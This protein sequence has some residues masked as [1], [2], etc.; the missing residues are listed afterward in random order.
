MKK[1]F[2]GA[3]M[4]LCMILGMTVFAFADTVTPLN[5]TGINLAEAIGSGLTDMVGEIMAVIAV[6]LPMALML[7]GAV[8]AIR[9]GISLMRS[10]VS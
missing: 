4:S 10:L 5:S 6:I 2:F 9:K 7:V 3:I 1:W 8:I